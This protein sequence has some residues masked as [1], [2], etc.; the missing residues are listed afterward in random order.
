MKQPNIILVMNDHQAYYRHGWDGG[1]KPLRPNFDKLASM[2]A[3]FMNAYSACP[4]CA[5]VRRSMLNGL[6]PHTHKNYYNDSAVPYSEESYLKVLSNNGYKSYYLGKWHAGGHPSLPLHGSEGFTCEGYGNPY[7]TEEYKAYC[8][9]NNLPHATHKIEVDFTGERVRPAFPELKEGNLYQS[10]TD[11]IY[12]EAA[13]VTTTPKETH[14]SFFLANL[15]CDCLEEH[16]KT[17]NEQPFMLNLQFWGPHQ[18]FFPT[19]EFVDMYDIEDIK[20]YESFYED[21]SNRSKVNQVEATILGDEN[22]KLIQPSVFSEEKWKKSLLYA[23]AS[24][25]MVDDAFG[26]IMNKVEELGLS[27]DT[28]IIYSTDHGDA[29]CSHGGHFD[30]CSYLTQEVL[31]I[32]MAIKWKGKIP[33]KTKIKSLVSN[34]DIPTTILDC[35]GLSFEKAVYGKSLLPLATMEKEKVRDY[36]VSETAGHG[37]I[38]RIHGRSIVSDGFKFICYENMEDE[39]YDLNSDPYEMKNLCRDE[40]YVTQLQSLKEKLKEWQSETKDP[41]CFKGV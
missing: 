3:E 38:E 8:E 20:M 32:P 34:I 18:P 9:K 21:M 10:L 13:G 6:Y 12:E 35:A 14:E 33:E 11:G 22:Y 2:G 40:N 25:T 36:F 19:Q 41:V 39:L 15:A 30:K 31:R 17:K 27:D 16:V 4:L 26:L 24:Q 28:I 7:L 29:L 5:P 37:Y 23:Y 1:V